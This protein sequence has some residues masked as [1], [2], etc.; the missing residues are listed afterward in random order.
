MAVSDHGGGGAGGSGGDHG[1][2]NSAGGGGNAGGRRTRRRSQQ[3]CRR[4]SRRRSRQQRR[5]SWRW[6]QQRSRQCGR[7]D[8]GSGRARRNRSS[9]TWHDQQP[10][11]HGDRG[12]AQ[13]RAQHDLAWLDRERDGFIECVARLAE[14]HV[15][16]SANFDGRNDWLLSRRDGH[17][18]RHADCYASPDCRAQRSD[19]GGTCRRVGACSQQGPT[20]SV[21]SAVDKQLGLPATDPTLGVSQP[22]PY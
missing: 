1:G 14:C 13:R 19:S 7:L 11:L 16:R 2:G 18:A 21:V 5:R 10:Q 12:S 9:V 15:A 6:Q 3:Q 8:S 22:S 17:R 20:P 4:Q